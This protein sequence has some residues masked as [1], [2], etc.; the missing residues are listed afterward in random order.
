MTFSDKIN[1]YALASGHMAVPILEEVY[2]SSL[3]VVGL[4]TQPDKAKGRKKVLCPTPV[5]AWADACGHTVDKPEN[6]NSPGFLEK[7]KALRLDLILVIAFGQIL[8]TPLL[9]LSELGCINV[10]FSL[11]PKYRGASPVASAIR[12][13][14]EK[15]GISIMKLNEGVDT[16]PVYCSSQFTST[17]KESCKELEGKLSH[18]AASQ[19]NSKLTQIYNGSLNS[20]EQDESQASYSGKIYKKDAELNWT[21][22][23]KVIERKM[24]A[25]TPWPGLFFY[26]PGKKNRRR[27]ILTAC[28]IVP[29]TEKSVPGTVQQADK[30]LWIVSTGKDSLE[31]TSVIPEGKKEMSG[32]DFLRG[33]QIT[34]GMK[35]LTEPLCS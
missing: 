28:K 34:E 26:M 1:V 10:H 33:C 29:T 11:L 35:L 7:L 14:E 17:N 8:K 25:Y 23:A 5:G 20:V 12:D 27:L 13:G 32:P 3:N 24:R 19:I 21:E 2:N 22:S 30:N 6:V 31:L 4:A 16:G 9:N 15:F 18:L